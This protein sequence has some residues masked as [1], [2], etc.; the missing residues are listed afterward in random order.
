MN[1]KNDTFATLNWKK[2]LFKNYSVCRQNTYR[3]VLKQ[4]QIW[5]EYFDS[6]KGNVS[7][8]VASEC[9]QNG[10]HIGTNICE[11]EIDSVASWQWKDEVGIIVNNCST[12]IGQYHPVD[13]R[14]YFDQTIEEA[15]ENI[16]F[17]SAYKFSVITLR[18][19]GKDIVTKI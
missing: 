6:L 10:T 5:P 15:I 3:W 4:Y 1:K 11:K 12:I 13:S 14:Y 9:V 16:D 18:T 8:H 7:V 19:V 17:D 2:N